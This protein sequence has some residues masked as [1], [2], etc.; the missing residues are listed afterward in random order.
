MLATYMI[1]LY[2]SCTLLT[3]GLKTCTSLGSR[4]RML[5]VATIRGSGSSEASGCLGVIFRSLKYKSDLGHWSVSYKDGD[6]KW[7]ASDRSSPCSIGLNATRFS[8]RVK[9]N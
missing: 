7:N 4:L 1:E 6:L 3:H 5:M 2:T 8:R 9:L